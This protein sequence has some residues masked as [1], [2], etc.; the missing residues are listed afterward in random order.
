MRVSA[1]RLVLFLFVSL[2]SPVAVHAQATM[3]GTIRDASGAVLPGVSVEASSPALIEKTR[4]AVTDGTGQYR[5][6][7]LPPGSYALT[8]TL[9]G[10]TTV[11]REIAHPGAAPRAA[12]LPRQSLA[13]R[14]VHSGPQRQLPRILEVHAHLVREVGVPEP[15]VR[16]GEG[17]GAPGAGDAERRRMPEGVAR[18]RLGEAQREGD[19]DLE[20]R[21]PSPARV[22]VGAP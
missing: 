21:V 13:D 18:V 20:T 7:N 11:R 2:V 14:P 10:F 6:I 19:L 5:L 12:C 15:G 22:G 16:I 17:E 3:A 1:T 9:Q 4:T 8:I